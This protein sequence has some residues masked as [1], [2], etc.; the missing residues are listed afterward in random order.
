MR[1]E[2]A[3]QAEPKLGDVLVGKYRLER[4]VGEGGMGTVFAAH[5]EVL[6]QTVAVKILA[7]ELAQSREIAERFLQEARAAAKLQSEHVARVMDAGISETGLTF[8]VM[9]CLDGY[10]LGELMKIGGPPLPTEEVVD[11]ALEALEGLAHAHRAGIIHRDIKPGNLFLATRT[12]GPSVIKLL[13]FGISK[14][15]T[16][17]VGKEF[18]TL[19]GGHQIIGSP[20]YMSP[21]QV[22]DPS[23]VDGRS[24]LWSLGIVMYELLTGKPAFSGQGPMKIFSSILE[25]ALAP[26]RSVREDVPEGLESVIARCTQRDRGKRYR[27]VAELA[28]ALAPYG[29]ARS[30]PL[31]ERIETLMQGIAKPKV[32]T[33]APASSREEQL[34]ATLFVPSKGEPSGEAKAA[35]VPRLSG[36][37]LFGIVV[38]LALVGAGLYVAATS[39]ASVDAG[40]GEGGTDT[41]VE[42]AATS[43][44]PVATPHPVTP[45]PHP[46]HSTIAVPTHA[47]LTKPHPAPTTRHHPR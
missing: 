3:K 43:S 30:A 15:T 28:R 38:V 42:T 16:G 17:R 8:I 12:G 40:A 5:H 33:L 1:E 25:N 37:A 44:E 2:H 47:P 41:E 11:Y 4:V 9:E 34:A 22:R 6:D 46:T 19:T 23:T 7:P 10:D 13:D 45:P 14:A 31:V 24:D 21:E 29:S 18:R 36:A 32:D 35:G 26:L 39:G 20:G 27:D